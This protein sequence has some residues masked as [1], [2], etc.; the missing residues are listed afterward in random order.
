MGVGVGLP[1]VKGVSG[2]RD[3][4][5]DELKLSALLPIGVPILG[6]NS[7]RAPGRRSVE[8]RETG[9]RVRD[10]AKG[11]RGK[12]DV[13][14]RKRPEEPGATIAEVP[15]AAGPDRIDPRYLVCGHA[16]L[17]SE[18]AS[19]RRAR[20]FWEAP[21]EPPESRSAFQP[22]PPMPGLGRDVLPATRS[23]PVGSREGNSQIA[24]VSQ[25]VMSPSTITGT[26]P[27]ACT[28][29]AHS[30]SSVQCRGE[31]GSPRTEFRSPSGRATRGATRTSSSCCRLRAST[32]R[33]GQPASIGDESERLARSNLGVMMSA[34]PY[35]A[36][37]R[38]SV[39][40]L[41]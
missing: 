39:T 23:H 5:V 13:G 25:T 3:E 17:A 33:G 31:C 7:A 4:V 6:W 2:R 38:K 18:S 30:A 1:G 29:R 34:L 35:S 26:R 20:T 21:R 37:A 22:L 32:R 8:R 27:R 16:S 14:D 41:L 28:V 19:L 10:E 24:S 11:H 9:N 12:H 40:G 36:S 15:A